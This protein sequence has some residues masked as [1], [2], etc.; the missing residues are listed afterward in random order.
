[1]SGVWG[2]RG[3]VAE[4]AVNLQPLW[5]TERQARFLVTVMLH[6][7][8]FLKHQSCRGLRRHHPRA[9]DPRLPRPLDRLWLC[10]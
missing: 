10:A 6:S 8:V 3:L 2:F 1:M 9:E 7:G 5:F 4:R